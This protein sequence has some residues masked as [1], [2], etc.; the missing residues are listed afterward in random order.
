MKKSGYLN[1]AAAL[2]RVMA[3]SNA[4]CPD[5]YCNAIKWRTGAYVA[6]REVNGEGP[7]RYGLPDSALGSG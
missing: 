2:L 3:H 6:A 1:W 4:C 5:W 7:C